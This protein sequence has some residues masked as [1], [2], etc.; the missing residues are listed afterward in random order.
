MSDGEGEGDH[1]PGLPP[2]VVLAGR[3]VHRRDE[4]VGVRD[5]RRDPQRRPT[6]AE[7]LQLTERRR[8]LGARSGRAAGDQIAYL[9]SSGQLVDLR[10]A[11]LE[12]TGPT[13]TVKDAAR[14][15]LERRPRRRL[16]ARTGSCP[17]TSAGAA[18]RRPSRP[19][20]PARPPP[21]SRYDRWRLPRAAR[22]ADRGHAVGPVRRRSTPRPTP[23]PPASR[24]RSRASSA[25]PGSSLEASLPVATAVKPNLAFFEAYGADGDRRARA[26]AGA[27]PGRR[28]VRRRRQARRHR[29]HGGPPGGRR[30][31]TSWARTPSRS[32]RTSARR[33]SRRCSSAATAS[34][35]SCAGRRTRA[36]RELQGLEVAADDAA[37][38]PAEPLYA[39]VARRVDGLGPGRHGRARRR[40]HGPRGDGRDP[41]ASRR[42]SRSS[43]RASGR[44]AARSSPSSRA[45]PRRWRRPAAGHGGGLLVNVSRGHRPGS[46]RTTPRRVRQTDPGER[47]AEAARDWAGRLAVLP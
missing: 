34:P 6:G 18:D 14:P 5:G 24:R 8:Q 28:A 46:P 37:G 3:Q 40:R 10:L 17:R 12:G 11:Q 32:T 38:R 29:H 7:L 25:S 36:R 1:R 20:T 9:H 23:C 21:R 26:A 27:R 16:A 45:G 31:T 44:R 19:R 33:R 43:C 30:C 41:R 2:A 22:R 15:D 47:L 4:D 35:T 42:V 13:W 39:R